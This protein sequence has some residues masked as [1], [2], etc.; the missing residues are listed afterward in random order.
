MKSTN[1]L[2]EVKSRN[3]K[4]ILLAKGQLHEHTGLFP[5]DFFEKKKEALPIKVIHEE[6]VDK[7]K[8]QC[9]VIL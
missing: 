9:C 4:I 2:I 1:N 8:S 3:S 5:W 7:N 6:K